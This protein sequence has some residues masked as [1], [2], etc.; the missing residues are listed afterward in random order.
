LPWSL[1]EMQLTRRP[2]AAVSPSVACSHIRN[3]F[4]VT[5]Q[6]L[7]HSVKLVRNFPRIC[8]T[9]SIQVCTGNQTS[10]RRSGW[11]SR[12]FASEWLYHSDQNMP[13]HLLICRWNS[14]DDQDANKGG[15]PTFHVFKW[16]FHYK[17]CQDS[18]L[19]DWL[20]VG[21]T[22]DCSWNTRG[23][24]AAKKFIYK[25]ISSRKASRSSLSSIPTRPG[26]LA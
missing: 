5:V 25:K 19:T 24:L 15:L 9:P 4:A 14:T 17:R 23:V 26:V 10:H 12:R 8:S 1:C 6:S 18:W 7:D 20:I 16:S 11:T 2:D 13:R 21:L 22:H 3:S